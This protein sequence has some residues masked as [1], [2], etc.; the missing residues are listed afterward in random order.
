MFGSAL[1]IWP[2]TPTTIVADICVTSDAGS[3][4]GIKDDLCGTEGA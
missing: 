4:S 2:T 3:L 1:S